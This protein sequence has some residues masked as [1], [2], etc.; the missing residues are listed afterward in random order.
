MQ[1][2]KKTHKKDRSSFSLLGLCRRSWWVVL[3]C[4]GCFT[5]YA[6]AVQ[7]KSKDCLDL[8]D[9]IGKLR[10]E[11]EGIT[12]LHEDLLLQIGSQSDP[13]WIE[14]TLKKQLGVVPE[15]QKKVY[16]KKDE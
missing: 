9:R 6:Q 12:R 7:K 16:F 3:F 13:Q 14:L 11:K 2:Q 1:A 4:C 10:V 15:G 5:V 8:R